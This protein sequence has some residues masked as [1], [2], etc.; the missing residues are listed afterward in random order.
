MTPKWI[1]L[2]LLIVA[3]IGPSLGQDLWH[4]EPPNWWVGM[5]N[6]QLQI[7]VHGE[8]VQTLTPEVKYKGIKVLR[9]IPGENPNYL[10]LDL[11]I[12]P[13]T[14]PGTA[15]IVLKT[16]GK[17]IYSFDYQ[18]ITRETHSSEREGYDSKD[19]IY[20][21]TPDRFSNGDKNNDQLDGMKETP[22][23]SSKNGRHGGD[24]EGIE[25]HLDYI[26][27]LGMTAIWLNPFLENNMDKYSYHGYAITDFYKTD[28]RMG[29]NE[30]FRQLSMTAKE[31]GIKMIMDQVVNHCGLNHWWIKDPPSHDWINYQD[32]DY[33]E[34]N[35]LKS[36]PMDPYA[37]PEDEKLLVDGWFVRTMPDLNVRNPFMATYLIQNSIWWIEYAGL[38]GIRMDTYPYPDAEFMSQW[39]GQIR[40]EYPNLTITGEVWHPNPAFVAYWQDGNKNA[41][42]YQ[43]HLPSVF[44]FPKQS[45]L[46]QAL[47]TEDKYDGGWKILYE[48]VAQDYQYPDPDMLVV[49]G[50][51]HDTPRLYAQLN[52]DLQ[53]FMLATTFLCTTRGIPQFFYGSEILM[54]S[55]AQRDDGLVRSD[56]PGGWDG[57]AKNGFTGAGLTDDE[58]AAQAFV[59]K[60]LQWRIK[61]TA[62]H[63]GQLIHYAPAN[64]MYVYFRFNEDQK[65]MIILNKNTI[66][67]PMDLGRFSSQLQNANRGVEIL[68]GKEISMQ[69]KTLPVPPGPTIIEIK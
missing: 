20:L 6:T 64:G 42:H 19:A 67:T 43:S 16:G 66:E 15:K 47:N 60:I 29:S 45:A 56:F 7:M 26:A 3:V 38:N 62:I 36:L 33:T 25:K 51:N 59:K 69:N 65:L 68:S 2:I 11:E 14:K 55:P 17:E 5:K 52:S 18:L 23:R 46:I 44:D 12:S 39:A 8:K 13:K 30:S 41:S 58:K 48:T 28:S 31:K 27:D 35:H 40:E 22:D 54:T 50:D 9:S 1:F 37:A 63:N 57:D 32:Q 53:K 49:F 34:T 24:L 61:A 21:I 10:F 4:V